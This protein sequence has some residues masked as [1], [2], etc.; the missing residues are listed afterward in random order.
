MDLVKDKTRSIIKQA[1]HFI[2]ENGEM[3]DYHVANLDEIHQSDGYVR[4]VPHS[5]N[6]SI[7]V[8][9]SQLPG[10]GMKPMTAFMDYKDY[11]IEY[12]NRYKLESSIDSSKDNYHC[13]NSASNSCY[14]KNRINKEIR[15]HDREVAR[16]RGLRYEVANSEWQL[17]G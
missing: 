3:A 7:V 12:E 10:L 4:T 5:K 17:Q 1:S 15:N 14:E 9:R 6:K 16:Q 8:S 2:T 13:G 11:R